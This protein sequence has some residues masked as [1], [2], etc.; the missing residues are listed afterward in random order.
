MTSKV[1]V[2]VRDAAV[3]ARRGHV[4]HALD[5][6]DRLLER[7]RDRGLDFLRVG[8]GVERGD[9]DLRRREARVLRDRHRRDGDRAGEDQDERADRREDR[10]ADEGVDEHERLFGPATGAPSPIFWMPET[11]S[12]SPA[13]RPLGDDV[14]V[15]DQLADLN[16]LLPRDQAALRAW[17]GHEAEVLAADARRRP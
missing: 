9:V 5:A 8:A 14:V 3:G 17:F 10:T 2:I 1:T 13:L 11:I 15:A 16:R 12:V 6:V 4:E 7:R